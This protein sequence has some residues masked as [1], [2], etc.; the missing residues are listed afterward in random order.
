MKSIEG[1]AS[2][3]VRKQK[4]IFLF[5]FKIQMYFDA[6]PMQSAQEVAKGTIEV[7]EFN[8]DDDDIDIDVTCEKSGDFVAGVKKVL[9]S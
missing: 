2:I 7:H 9:T 3:T 8:Q 6:T 4:Q 1:G 5:E